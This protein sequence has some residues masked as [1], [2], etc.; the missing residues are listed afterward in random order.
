MLRIFPVFV[1][2]VFS[3]TSCIQDKEPLN[4]RATHVRVQE[5]FASGDIT[6]ALHIIHSA[7]REIQ[8]H[9]ETRC[10][11]GK[12]FF[13]DNKEE[14]AHSL[15]TNLTDQYPEFTEARLWLIR[16]ELSLGKYEQAKASLNR[17]LRQNASDWRFLYQYALLGRLLGDTELEIGM[18]A[19]A[20]RVLEDAGR[21]YVDQAVVWDGLALTSRAKRA[22]EKASIITGENHPLAPIIAQ[23]QKNKLASESEGKHDENK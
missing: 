11:E 23:I 2:L 5:R 1:I 14:Q 3:F 12:L 13:L 4:L 9:P 20:S 19:A 15:F 16:C 18:L 17:E 21:V 10:L 22:L 6:S 8:K 7:S